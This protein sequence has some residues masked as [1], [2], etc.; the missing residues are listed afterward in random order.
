M[1][2]PVR[3][4][5]VQALIFASLAAAELAKAD[6]A[7][8]SS[9]HCICANSLTATSKIHQQQKHTENGVKPRF[10]RLSFDEANV[11]AQETP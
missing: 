1:M 11:A 4:V 5:P 3:S 8:A 2:Q 10:S 9:L 6:A 7:S